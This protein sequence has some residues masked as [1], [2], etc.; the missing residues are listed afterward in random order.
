MEGFQSRSVPAP[1]ASEF[2]EPTGVVIQGDGLGHTK[3]ACLLRD[4]KGAQEL[5]FELASDQTLLFGV[6]QDLE[7]AT[8]AFPLAHV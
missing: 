1:G 3:I 4:C 8:Q 7:R 6:M 5:R 2:P